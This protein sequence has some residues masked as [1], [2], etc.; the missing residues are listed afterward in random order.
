MSD[1]EGH[2]SGLRPIYPPPG[3]QFGVPI[4]PALDESIWWFVFQDRDEEEPQREEE[5]P[6]PPT[7]TSGLIA[8]L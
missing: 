1:A 5:E 7:S 2:P 8:D 6:Q 3:L 4:P